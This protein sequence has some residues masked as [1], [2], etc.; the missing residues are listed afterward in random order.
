MRAKFTKEFICETITISYSTVFSI[1]LDHNNI[2]YADRYYFYNTVILCKLIHFEIFV[3]IKTLKSQ[4]IL[5]MG[6][7]SDKLY[8]PC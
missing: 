2:C 6:G 8:F 4:S 5:E 3:N 7:S 1:M